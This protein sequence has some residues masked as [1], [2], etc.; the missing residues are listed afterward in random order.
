MS[1]RLL[2]RLAL[3]CLLVGTPVMILLESGAARGV[4]VAL[5]VAFVVFGLFAVASPD[6]LA[7]GGDDQ[8]EEGDGEP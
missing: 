8:D 1:E 3:A 5:I 6:Y 2:T 4:G 7:G